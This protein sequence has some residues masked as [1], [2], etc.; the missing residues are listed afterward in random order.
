MLLLEG[1]IRI[2]A[3]ANGADDELLI[4]DDLFCSGRTAVFADEKHSE[5]VNYGTA[6]NGFCGFIGITCPS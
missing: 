6:N 1:R 5:S 2:D 3:G 4:Y